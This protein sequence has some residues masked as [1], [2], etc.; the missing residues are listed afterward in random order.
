VL[1]LRPTC[2]RSASLTLPLRPVNGN[3]SVTAVEAGRGPDRH[4]AD[5]NSQ[6]SCVH[7]ARMVTRVSSRLR[8][9]T[10][11]K[12]TR[13]VRKLGEF[14]PDRPPVRPTS[15]RVRTTMEWD[16]PRPARQFSKAAAA[17]SRRRAERLLRY[18]KENG[19]R[20][21]QFIARARLVEAGMSISDSSIRLF[22]AVRVS[23]VCLLFGVT[24]S[25]ASR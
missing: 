7:S 21:P 11:P 14:L 25:A 13:K 9:A 10:M 20:N 24:G 18:G 2:R 3:P 8:V 5:R 15:T 22:V 23:V 17:A 6:S 12:A 1:R 4:T 16:N 19:Y